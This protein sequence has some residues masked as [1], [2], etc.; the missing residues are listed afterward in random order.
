MTALGR[1]TGGG[2][3]TRGARGHRRPASAG[4]TGRV[5]QGP[6]LPRPLRP[7]TLSLA[8]DGSTGV[9][10]LAPAERGSAALSRS[11]PGPSLWWCSPGGGVAMRAVVGSI[12][13][14]AAAVALT[15][16]LVAAAVRE[17]N[18]GCRTIGVRAPLVP[19]GAVL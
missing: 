8:A 18:Y 14:L 4:P 11:E 6:P 3:A 12:L 2:V 9:T 15:G 7:V 5:V 16:G 19:R 17:A 1:R 13:F 10:S